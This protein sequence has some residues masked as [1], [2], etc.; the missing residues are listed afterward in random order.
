MI[1]NSYVDVRVFINRRTL[2]RN[3][4]ERTLDECSGNGV[5]M[6]NYNKKGG[7]NNG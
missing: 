7:K 1:N 4:R 2:S 6:K 3:L 5:N